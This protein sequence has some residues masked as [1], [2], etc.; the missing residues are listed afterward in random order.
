[1]YFV[2]ETKKGKSLF[3]ILFISYHLKNHQN[4][5]GDMAWTIA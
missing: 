3:R 2:C 1:M 4:F 5:K